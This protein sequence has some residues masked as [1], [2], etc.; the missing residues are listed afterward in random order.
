MR[1]Q[2]I[3]AIGVLTATSLTVVAC[4]TATGSQPASAPSVG[5]TSPNSI[6]TVKTSPSSTSTVKASPSSVRQSSPAAGPT[7]ASAQPTDTGATV[8]QADFGH[9]LAAWKG[10]AAAPMASMNTYLEQAADDLRAA[11]DSGYDT[12]ISQLTN[13]LDLPPTDDTPTQQAKA[14]SDVKALDSFFGTPGL[15]S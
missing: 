4:G 10:A 3:P 12:A 11:G 7:Q 1:L 6:S 15:M 2:Y 13:L 5:K 9:A 14:Q 8:A